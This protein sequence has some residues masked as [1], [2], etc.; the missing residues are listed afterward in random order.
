MK[1]WCLCLKR[2]KNIS[3]TWKRCQK[4]Y[5]ENLQNRQHM[6][7]LKSMRLCK[8]CK[9]WK[10]SKICRIYKICKTKPPIL[11]NLYVFGT[12]G[13]FCKLAF[14]G[15]HL[16]LSVRNSWENSSDTFLN[17]E[18]S[19]GNRLEILT[20]F[21]VIFTAKIKKPL[22]LWRQVVWNLEQ[23]ILIFYQT[24]VWFF[25]YPSNFNTNL[26][27]NCHPLFLF[28]IYSYIVLNSATLES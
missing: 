6:Y 18:L 9:R 5:V 23:F 3:K 22:C 20:F 28:L 21:L 26:L 24:W 2:C 12:I 19:G 7:T 1:R 11:P 14:Y 27:T 25:V 15:W 13:F 10:I 4:W 17:I 8:R 16:K